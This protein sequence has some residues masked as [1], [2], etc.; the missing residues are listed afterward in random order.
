MVKEAEKFAEDDK[1]KKEMVETINQAE[2]AI[3]DIES[4]MDEFKDQLPTEE[5]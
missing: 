4:K 5:V 1:K 3:L 2:N